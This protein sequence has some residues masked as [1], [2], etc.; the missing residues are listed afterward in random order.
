MWAGPLFI[1]CSII[2][3]K[4]TIKWVA[5][6]HNIKYESLD[7]ILNTQYPTIAHK[8]GREA[9][10]YVLCQ[11][12]VLLCSHEKAVAEPFEQPQGWNASL[13]LLPYSLLNNKLFSELSLS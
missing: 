13:V 6:Y 10:I 8:D 4:I 7:K 9:D 1:H 3:I 11:W 2:F 5:I 12:K